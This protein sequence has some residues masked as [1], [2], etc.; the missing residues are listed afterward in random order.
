MGVCWNIG[1]RSLLR[2]NHVIFIID[3]VFNNPNYWIIYSSLDHL[4]H[5]AHFHK[6][7]HL[8]SSVVSIICILAFPCLFLR[9]RCLRFHSFLGVKAIQLFGYHFI[10]HF[11][12]VVLILPSILLFIIHTSSP[13]EHTVHDI[14]IWS[15]YFLS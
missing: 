8:I 11:I 9:Y 4:P 2:S 10:S 15:Q 5:L 14:L 3:H 1:I 6:V 7:Y 12:S 13:Y